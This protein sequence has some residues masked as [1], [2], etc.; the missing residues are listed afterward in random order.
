MNSPNTTGSI[1]SLATHSHVPKSQYFDWLGP[2][3]IT[4]SIQTSL[5]SLSHSLSL[6]LVLYTRQIIVIGRLD[7]SWSRG[8]SCRCHVTVLATTREH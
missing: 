1:F 3:L 5:D 2:R 6:S 7:A 8:Y 4:V